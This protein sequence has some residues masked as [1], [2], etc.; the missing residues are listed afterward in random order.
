MRL[1][2]TGTDLDTNWAN[3][4]WVRNASQV[5]PSA[6]DQNEFARLFHGLYAAH[7]MPHVNQRCVQQ[8]TTLLYY[9][10]TEVS[11]GEYVEP[12]QGGI[13]PADN[14]PAHCAT[15]ISWHVQQHYRGGHPRTYLPPAAVSKL[16]SPTSFAT[17][18]MDEV[19]IAA[20]QFLL[21]VNSLTLPS[22]SSFHLGVVSFVHKKQWRNP[23]V[24]RDFTPA[25]TIVDR[26]IDSQRRRL[27]PDV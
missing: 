8:K 4:F 5:V 12:F 15:G 18:F 22:S 23:P 2:V 1:A 11:G 13:T 3:I 16:S 26:R 14:F 17:A 9:Q 6:P 25:A 27:G 20:N 10:A 7:L 21:A 19:R 24:F